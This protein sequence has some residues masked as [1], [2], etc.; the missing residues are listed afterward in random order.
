MDGKKKGKGKEVGFGKDMML[1][2]DK[3]HALTHTI[4]SLYEGALDS[5][6]FVIA[7]MRDGNRTKGSIIECRESKCTLPPSIQPINPK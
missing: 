5:Q 1:T 7:A 4:S 2:G 6:Y 3:K